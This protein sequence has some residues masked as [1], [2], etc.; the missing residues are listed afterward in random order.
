[1][2]FLDSFER[3]VERLVGGTFAKAFSSGV[4]PGEIVA[5]LKREIDSR[6]KPVTRTRTVAPHNYRCGLSPEDHA[7]LTRLGDALR[8]EICAALLDYASVRGYSLADKLTLSLEVTTL[9]S[10]GMVE[11]SSSEL[12]PVVWVPTLTW[13]GVRY[14]IIKK[15][16]ILGRGTDSDIHLVA[17]GVSRHHSEIRWDGKRAEIVDLGS[18]NGTQLEGTRVTRAALPDRCTLGLGQARILFE[19]VPQAE[20]AYRSLAHHSSP[21]AEEAP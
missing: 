10:E 3:S 18:T 20:S 8:E 9:L 21:S 7:R 11:V 13:D 12:G 17:R 4:H 15:S 16:T 14:P 2:G 6:A 19:V 1:M 5:A